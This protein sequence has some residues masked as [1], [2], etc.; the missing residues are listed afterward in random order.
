MLSSLEKLNN[1]SFRTLRT[2]VTVGETGS[3]TV[4]AERLGRTPGAVSAAIQEF[5]EAVGVQVFVRKPAKGMALTSYGKLLVLEARGL[6]AHADDFRNIA[7]ALGSALSGNLSIACFSNLAPI[8]LSHLIA[9][10]KRQYAGINIQFVLGDQET[11]LQS[12]NSGAAEL[13][14]SFDIGLTD[15]IDTTPLATLPACAVL[16]ADHPLA[17][18]ADVSLVDLIDEPFILMDLPFT[19][20]YFLSI[21]HALDL[22]PKIAY[23]S[24]SFETVRTLVGN[25]LGYSLLNLEPKASQT[26]DGTSVVHVPLREP[27]KPLHMVLMM[28]KGVTRR[29]IVYTFKDYTCGHMKSWRANNRQENSL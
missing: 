16:P 12:L 14:I 21:F 17:A 6:L 7:G 23:R 19:R 15:N 13:A 28:L 29:S 3:V 2:L 5:E 27:H 24:R 18:A 26:Y 20:E 10:F 11:V 22:K 8:V 25:G 4:A 9:G 1:F